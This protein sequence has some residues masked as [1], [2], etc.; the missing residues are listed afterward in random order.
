MT[1]RYSF[2]LIFAEVIVFIVY[3]SMWLAVLSP[4]R[5]ADYI[6]LNHVAGISVYNGDV[7]LKED[8]DEFPKGTVLKAYG[9]NWKDLE[10]A[11]THESK[12]ISIPSEYLIEENVLYKTIYDDLHKMYLVVDSS[13]NDAIRLS[14][15][16]GAILIVVPVVT[17]IIGKKHALFVS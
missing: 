3:L 1:P 2:Y 13:Y 15:I 5:N 11:I 16:F 17:A 12:Y 6:A 7:T 9:I 4:V 8:Y 14:C 10:V